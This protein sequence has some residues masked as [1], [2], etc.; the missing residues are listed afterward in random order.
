MLLITIIML[1]KSANKKPAT[2]VK[3]QM[4]GYPSYC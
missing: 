2:N 3:W 4:S 1:M